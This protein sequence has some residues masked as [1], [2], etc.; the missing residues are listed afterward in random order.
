MRHWQDDPRLRR[1]VAERRESGLSRRAFLAGLGGAAGAAVLGGAKPA[2]AQKKV[3]VTMWDTEP[4]PAT[5]AAVKAIVE[6][7]QKLHKD[8]EVRAEGM[9]WGDM[10][11]KL[12]AAMAAKSPPTASHAQTYVVTSFRAKGLIEPLDDVVNAIGKDRIFPSVLQWLEYDGRFWGLTHAWGVDNLGGRGDIAREAGVNPQSWKTWDDWLRD[13][14]KLNKPPQHY[15]MSMSG[16]TFFVNEDV[17]MWTGSNGGRLFDDQ[18]NPQLESRQV[19][20]ML[21]FWK[22]VRELPRRQSQ[23]IALHY[24]EDRSVAEI[25]ETALRIAA[26]ICIYTNDSISVVTL[27]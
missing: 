18:G 19:L 3:T 6:D 13:L 4:N 21:E 17:Y 8:I 14:P 22:K 23:V 5:R 1:L 9:G 2:G 27:P 16:I 20:E 26:E 10:D 25:A 24:L 7:F 15:A 11:R 12:Q